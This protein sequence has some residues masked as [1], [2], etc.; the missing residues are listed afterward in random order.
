MSR[1]YSAGVSET[2]IFSANLINELSLG[3][4]RDRA[5]LLQAN[6]ATQQFSFHNTPFADPS[7]Y[8]TIDVVGYPSFGNGAISDKNTEVEDSWDINENLSY[9]R[10]SHDFKIG[11]ESIRARF[12]NRV[13]L[14]AFF[15]YVDGLPASLGFSGSGFAD[16]LLGTP[17]EG[18]TFQGTGKADGVSRS[19]YAGYFQDNWKVH[20]RLTLNIGMRYEFPQPW[21]DLNSG[22]NRLSTFDTSAYSQAI[23]GRFLLAGTPNSYIPG[24]GLVRGS[25]AALVGDTIVSPDRTDFQPRAGFA[26]RPL[27]NNQTSIRGGFGIYYSI[28]DANSVAFEMASPPFEFQSTAINL[29]PYVPLGQPL[30]DSEFFPSSGPAGAGSEGDYPG[31]RDPRI[32]QWQ[33]DVQHQLSNNVLF[34]AEYLGNH[35]LKLP[36]ALLIQSGSLAECSAVKH[37]FG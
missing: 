24:Q 12:I 30:H 16:F 15:V 23:G 19:I 1:S 29:P 27:N 26:Y 35:G 34:S 28:Q 22:L 31:N 37:A 14:N 33:I 9:L 11:F 8:P 4:T 32:Y 17:F 25:G 18:V 20:P 2:H 3:Y 36:V 5:S 7:L 10:G 13:N 21:R 6:N